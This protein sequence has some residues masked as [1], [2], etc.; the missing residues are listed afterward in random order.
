M[1]V[2]D[3]IL[4]PPATHPWT[5]C[6]RHPASSR[7]R[8][9]TTVLWLPCRASGSCDTIFHSQGA[10]V[11]QLVLGPC[12]LKWVQLLHPS[13]PPPGWPICPVGIL[14]GYYLHPKSLPWGALPSFSP[15]PEA[16]L[17]LPGSQF[18]CWRLDLWPQSLSLEGP[19]LYPCIEASRTR[20]ETPGA[21]P[22]YLGYGL[23]ASLQLGQFLHVHL[24]LMGRCHLF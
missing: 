12:V 23:W 15:T 2:T 1:Q 24:P 4:S 20:M 3:Q 7:R 22:W 5:Q 21:Q 9:R 14:F 16:H 6:W 19:T 11:E 17:T 8:G 18:P 13:P 10:L